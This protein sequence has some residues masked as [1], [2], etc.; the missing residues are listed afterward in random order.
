MNRAK[1][2][3][4]N[5]AKYLAVALLVFIIVSPIYWILVCSFKPTRE[6][7][8]VTPTFVPHT[9][10]LFHYVGLLKETG[11][12]TYFLNSIYVATGSAVLV[13]ILTSLAGYSVYRCRYLGRRFFF[14]I[15]LA[16]YIFPRVLLL[17]FL[18]PMFARLNLVD[19]LLSLVITYVGITAPLNVWLMRAFFTSVPLELED[20]ALVDGANRLQILFKIFLPLVA[21]GIGA[22]AINSFLMSYGEYLFASILIVSDRFKTLPVGMAQFLQQYEISWG[23][24]ASGSVLI[25]LPPVIAFAFVGRYFVKG[26]TA[27]AIK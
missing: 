26:L 6:L 22:V 23:W 9:V 25:I 8:R 2:F 24:L 5:L 17:L 4:Q 27:G 10:T 11:F 1:K 20:A 13:V 7:I 19:N 21:P 3:F 18:Y 15:L 12:M 16:I 14:N